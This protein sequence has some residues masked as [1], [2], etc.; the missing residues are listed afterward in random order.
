MSVTVTVRDGRGGVER[1]RREDILMILQQDRPVELGQLLELPDGS[2]APV[3][4]AVEH[5]DD[6]GLSQSVVVGDPSGS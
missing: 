2:A 1:A 6:R 5:A 4:E 3:V